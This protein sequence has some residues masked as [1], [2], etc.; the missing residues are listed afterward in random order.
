MSPMSSPDMTGPPRLSE[1]EKR[2]LELYDKL[3][4][5]Q[6]EL[7]LL[8]AQQ[9]YSRGDATQM[10]L[11]EAKAALAL[12]N[13]IL[14]SV[15]TVQPILEA[16]HHGTQ[17]SPVERDLSPY[18]EQRDRVAVRAAMQF[19]Q[20]EQARRSLQALE[21]ESVKVKDRNVQLASAVLRMADNTQRQSME[22]MDDARLKRELDEMENE[23]RASRQRW[24]VIKGTAG[25]VVV[26]S[27]ID[28]VQDERLR[29]LVLDAAD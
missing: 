27:G 10:N 16:V 6:I 12:R 23:V 17:A 15:M 20:S 7:A 4:E 18:V 5:L 1:T 29:G 21:V 3:Q 11:L 22:M 28:W 8:K 14:E 2:V 9:N 24:K 25:A 13:D 26:G 19:E